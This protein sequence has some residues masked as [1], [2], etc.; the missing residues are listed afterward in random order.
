M[1][2]G[3]ESNQG[4]HGPK[5]DALSTAPLRPSFDELADRNVLISIAFNQSVESSMERVK[6]VKRLTNHL[7]ET[8]YIV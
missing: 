5:S 1:C 3:G 8:V 7:N 2:T 4:P 6:T